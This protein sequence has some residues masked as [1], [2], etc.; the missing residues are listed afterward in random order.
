MKRSRVSISTREIASFVA[1][2]IHIVVPFVDPFYMDGLP[3][4]LDFY[5]WIIRC[6]NVP[7][8]M[9]KT[10]LDGTGVCCAMISIKC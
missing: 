10:V 8:S 6:G 9:T 2:S 3:V 1:V 7:T 5:A 4:D